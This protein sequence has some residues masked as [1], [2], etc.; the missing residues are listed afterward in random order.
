[1]LE[2]VGTLAFPVNILLAYIV[3]KIEL[4]VTDKELISNDEIFAVSTARLPT[5]FNI[6]ILLV[7]I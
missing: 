7:I 1:M 6:S 2:S 5:G 3:L 4:P